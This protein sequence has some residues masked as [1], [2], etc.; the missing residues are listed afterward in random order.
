MIIEKREALLIAKE[1]MQTAKS[2]GID[3]EILHEMDL[4]DD[5]FEGAI[6]SLD[7][8]EDIAQHAHN[9]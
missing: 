9:A 8:G 2:M 4:S 1:F 6:V 7:R 5:A 3:V